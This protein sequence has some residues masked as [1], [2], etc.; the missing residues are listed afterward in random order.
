M[1]T[2]SGSDQSTGVAPTKWS[3]GTR[4]VEPE[5]FLSAFGLSGQPFE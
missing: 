4:A 2:P 5:P 1:R 3:A